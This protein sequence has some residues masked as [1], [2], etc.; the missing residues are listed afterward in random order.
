MIKQALREL[1]LAQF[2]PSSPPTDLDD[3]MP[4]MGGALKST[5]AIELVAHLEKQYGIQV[6]D[7]EINSDNFGSVNRIVAFLGRNGVY[8]VPTTSHVVELVLGR[9]KD[10]TLKVRA[11]AMVNRFGEEERVAVAQVLVDAAAAGKFEEALHTLDAEAAR[12]FPVQNLLMFYR[13]I[14]IIPSGSP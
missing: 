2:M 13:R 7:H 11:A 4:L 12:G 9:I 10:E 5:D 1:I 6:S 8:P 14:G 3:D